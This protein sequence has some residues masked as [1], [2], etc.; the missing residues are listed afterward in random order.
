MANPLLGA[1]CLKCGRPKIIRPDGLPFCSECERKMTREVAERILP[2]L[3]GRGKVV[4][5]SEV[6]K[7]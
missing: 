3:G 1:V 6:Q 5:K 7:D 4:L 2:K